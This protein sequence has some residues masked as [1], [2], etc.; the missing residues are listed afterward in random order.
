MGPVKPILGS[1]AALLAAAGGLAVSLPSSTAAEPSDQSS[2]LVVQHAIA[3]A[4]ASYGSGAVALVQRVEDGAVMAYPES[5]GGWGAPTDLSPDAATSG[6]FPPQLVLAPN[7]AGAAL[8]MEETDGKY[9]CVV[10]MRR[11]DGSWSSPHVMPRLDGLE[12]FAVNEQGDIAAIGWNDRN[13]ELLVNIGGAWHATHL[14]TD[15]DE[16][17]AGIDDSGT[18]HVAQIN[19]DHG[20]EGVI[21]VRRWT[22]T[23]GW[24]APDTVTKPNE[25]VPGMTFAV[26]PNGT[27]YVGVGT[28][29]DRW[30]STWDTD[31]YWPTA[32]YVVKRAPGAD[33]WRR[34]WSRDGAQN[35]RMVADAT[36]VRL[37]WEQQ[38]DADPKQ[39]PRQLSLLT[40]MLGPTRDAD[41]RAAH[42]LARVRGKGGQMERTGFA[43]VLAPV[44]GED[45]AA[46]WRTLGPTADIRRLGVWTPQGTEHLTTAYQGP[47]VYAPQTTVTSTPGWLAYESS[48]V[49]GRERGLYDGTVTVAPLG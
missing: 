29:S 9:E 26:Q 34:I 12:S 45:S 19:T 48:L 43:A 35:L 32:Y 17:Q 16:V 30:L 39:R 7:G 23:G 36:N 41:D 11:P 38:A 18:V 33:S 22:V 47:M 6:I 4:V 42:R 14:N 49:T 13:D 20:G 5:D 15:G 44:A 25:M 21:W 24:T 3:P 40:Q 37:L 10:R 1:L 8:W 27:E 46:T 2:V 31:A 28:V